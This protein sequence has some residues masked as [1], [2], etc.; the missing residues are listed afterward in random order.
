MRERVGR[1]VWAVAQNN[2]KEGVWQASPPLPTFMPV[3]QIP[4]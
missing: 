2:W 4:Y 3:S 1:V